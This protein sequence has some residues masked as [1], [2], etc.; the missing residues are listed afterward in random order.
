MRVS[1][2]HTFEQAQRDQIYHYRNGWLS[3]CAC[4]LEYT[5]RFLVGVILCTEKPN[6]L[7]I[8]VRLF[9]D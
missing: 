3:I 7:V 9:L 2:G 6:S 5:V 4:N 8:D 1:A